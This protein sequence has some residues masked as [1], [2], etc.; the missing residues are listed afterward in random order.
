MEIK[1]TN[2]F[3]KILSVD[4]VTTEY[5]NWLSDTKTNQF[6]ESRWKTYSLEQLKEY[7]NSMNLSDNNCLFGI[8]LSENKKHIG[9]IKIGN[10]NQ[11]HRFADI[12]LMIGDK[13]SLNKGYGIE[14]IKLATQ[15]AFQHLNLNKIIA[16]IYINNIA[17]YKSFIKSGYREVGIYK[18]HAFYNGNYVDQ[19]I[20]EILKDEFLL[21]N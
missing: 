12:G 11:I 3:I 6:L 5:V 2:I 17:S 4:D 15:Y 10:I 20:V 9:N 18:K 21:I 13:N 14:S 19:Y 1:S 16:G 8:F 7:V